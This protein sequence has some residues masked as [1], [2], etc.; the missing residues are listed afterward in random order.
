M[1]DVKDLRTMGHPKPV[2]K[3]K[4]KR[5]IQGKGGPSSGRAVKSTGYRINPTIL[6]A[7]RKDSEWWREQD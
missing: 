7:L 5:E 4:N 2:Q 6:E 3:P 1:N